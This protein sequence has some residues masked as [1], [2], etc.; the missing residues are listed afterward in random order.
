MAPKNA[1]G[2]PSRVT[3]PRASGRRSVRDFCWFTPK[4]MRT[5]RPGTRTSFSNSACFAARVDIQHHASMRH[6]ACHFLTG[7]HAAA[8]AFRTDAAVFMH[9]GVLLALLRAKPARGGADAEHPAHHFIIG[10]RP[11]GHDAAG[12]G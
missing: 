12:D 11:A 3:T 7:L 10:T 6:A 5:Q 9:A 1:V 2:C 4:G 8:A